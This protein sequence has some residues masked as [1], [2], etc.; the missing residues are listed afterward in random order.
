MRL[1]VFGLFIAATLSPAMPVMSIQPETASAQAEASDDIYNSSAGP[2]F[3]LP[4]WTDGAGWTAAE[5]YSTIQLADID[6]DGSDELLARGPNGITVDSW[7][8]SLG[9]WASVPGTGPFGDDAGWTKAQYYSTI[10]TADID[11][12]GAAEMIGRSSVGVE[13]YKWNDS[14][15]TQIGSASPDWG[16]STG[17]NQEK[18]Y[19]TI[20]L[21]DIDGDGSSELLARAASGIETYKWAG[22]D[23]TLIDSKNPA[24]SDGE[25]WKDQRFYSTIQT[26]DI[27]GDGKAELLA[28]GAGGMDA[29]EWNGSSWKLMKASSPKWSD[30]ENW[31]HE[32]YYSTIQTGDI[33]GD[34][35]A[36]LLARSATGMVAYGWS[37]SGWTHLKGSSPA[38]S[39]DNDWNKEEY[40]ATIQTGDING[41]G[42][43]ELLGRSS[44][45]IDAYGWNGS[46]WNVLTLSQPE[47]KDS[48]WSSA[49]NYLTIQTG[50]IDGDKDADLIAR[51][52]YGIRTWSY[53][54][55]STTG[56]VRPIAYG[57]P[58][59]TGDQ[60]LAYEYVN[61]YLTLSTADQELR[62]QYSTD[63]GTLSNYEDC[64]T[65][66]KGDSPW[67]DWTA[68]PTETCAP[69]NAGTPITPPSGLTLTDWNT[70]AEQLS[71]ELWFAKTVSDYYT[72]LLTLY[73]NIYADSANQMDSRAQ[74]FYGEDLSEKKVEASLESLFMLPLKLGPAF[75]K[76]GSVI[77]GLL[78]AA[79]TLGVSA[80]SSDS[81]QGAWKDLLAEFTTMTENNKDAMNT[82]QAYVVGDLGLMT[83]VAQQKE[84]GA[85][86]P[87]DAWVKRYLT[88]EGRRAEALWVYQTLSPALWEIDI[89]WY[90]VNDDCSSPGNQEYQYFTDNN[91]DADCY[92]QVIQKSS[93]FPSN[94]ILK[95]IMDPISDSCTPTQ[96]NS[97]TWEYGKCSVGVPRSD[98]FL[99]R[100]GWDFETNSVC[101]G[102][103]SQPPEMDVAPGDPSN[104]IDL[105]DP[106]HKQVLIY[107][108]EDFDATAIVPG[109]LVLAGASP[110][111]W[112]VDDE[113]WHPAR[114]RDYNGDGHLD[115]LAGFPVQ[116]MTELGSD[117]TEVTLTGT[118]TD[119]T[120]FSFTSPVTVVG[121]S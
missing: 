24:W 49:G 77:S 65:K 21:A 103:P 89:F 60:Q 109:S 118:L 92:R 61:T 37:G 2:G 55:S 112:W 20:Q 95:N 45:G 107:G 50:D 1:L 43:A 94:K 75:G 106:G 69:D 76:P 67:V 31:G 73:D 101:F 91:K 53:D 17:W 38:W 52:L 6:G 11:G 30:T 97:A 83:Y 27:N 34:G 121:G 113:A 8:A 35:K 66:S 108:Q 58:P 64:L 86:D 16:D 78:S 22:S 93:G 32:P 82:S 117:T 72:D 102:C 54:A 114:T 116:A 3:T 105:T 10:Q 119:G 98:F 80:S 96:D 44:G 41:D 74:E 15:W 56:W 39:D 104:T 70:V 71:G 42:K 36:E 26:G 40:Y 46:D 111:G 68:L 33:N 57:F 4:Q 13:T 90:L 29:Y 9:L 115:V 120:T 7:D 99:N 14:A 28:R 18:Y 25:G 63:A 81:F 19:A 84:S 88:S 110:V 87:G 23:W 48:H 59:F 62:G 5:Y 79:I 85:W 12:D 51:G 100:D 47:L